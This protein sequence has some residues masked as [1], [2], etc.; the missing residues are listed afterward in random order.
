M[1]TATAVIDVDQPLERAIRLL[2]ASGRQDRPEPP[3]PDPASASVDRD[4]SRTRPAHCRIA[5]HFEES[6]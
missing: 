4:R 2:P 5:M 6:A 3:E 1:T